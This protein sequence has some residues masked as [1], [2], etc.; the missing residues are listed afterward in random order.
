MLTSLVRIHEPS[1]PSSNTEDT[2]AEFDLNRPASPGTIL[3]PAQSALILFNP[4]HVPTSHGRSGQEV[5]YAPRRG[6]DKLLISPSS[7]PSSAG[8]DQS[9]ILVRLAD[10][11]DGEA[12]QGFAHYVWNSGVL[13]AEMILGLDVD[14]YGDPYGHVDRESDRDFIREKPW[15][16]KWNVEAKTVLELGAGKHESISRLSVLFTCFTPQEP[17]CLSDR[18]GSKRRESRM[19]E[20]SCLT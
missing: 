15:R 7:S 8:N 12:F 19:F 2:N 18:S 3:D 14:E 9:T 20:I 13:A 4:S 5:A 16:R 17:R 10:P 6:K 1:P 11:P